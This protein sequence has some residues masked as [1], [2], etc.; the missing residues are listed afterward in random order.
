MVPSAFHWR[1]GLP[2][3]ANGKTDRKALSALA[4]ELNSRVKDVQTPI[5]AAEQRV[6]AA[7]AEVLGVAQDRIGREDH[8][9]DRGGTSL[10]AAKL[11]ITLGRVV[12]LKDVIRHPILA[13]LAQ[14]VEEGAK[15]SPPLQAAPERDGSLSEA[16]SRRPAHSEAVMEI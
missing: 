16:R 9:F 15:S 12:S 11:V 6:A 3:T 4:E 1:D 8:F 13:D 7:W 2:L 14:L 5:T 10:S